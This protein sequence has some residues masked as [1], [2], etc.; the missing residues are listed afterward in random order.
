MLAS[1]VKLLGASTGVVGLVALGAAVLGA[2]VWAV[3]R[4]R[5][6][7]AP[8][9]WQQRRRKRPGNEPTASLEA[10]PG[11]EEARR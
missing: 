8:W 6:G 1:G 9:L 3:V 2:G 5:H 7:E 11:L 4:V 10:D